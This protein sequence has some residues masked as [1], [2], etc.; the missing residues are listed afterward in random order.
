MTLPVVYIAHEVRGET[1]EAI[2]KNLSEV[3]AI[4]A[5]TIESGEA[6][7]SAP[8]LY[9]MAA[10]GMEFDPAFR[11][12]GIAANK[13][14]FESGFVNEVW[15]TGKRISDGIRKEM[16]WALDLGLPI[17]CRNPDLLDEFRKVL[18]EI[19]AHG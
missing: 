18:D 6:F 19:V 8:Y 4:C 14:H 13:Q 15:V 16:K 9:L 3:A 2:Q 10:P 1:P 7:P 17:Q 5:Q 11:A 12:R